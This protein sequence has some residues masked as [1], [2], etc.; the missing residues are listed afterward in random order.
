MAEEPSSPLSEGHRF[1]I[2]KSRVCDR[3]L[4]QAGYTIRNGVAEGSRNCIQQDDGQNGI[5]SAARSGEGILSRTG[6][7]GAL[8]S[9]RRPKWTVDCFFSHQNLFHRRGQETYFGKSSPP[10]TEWVFEPE[11][12]LSIHAYT[13]TGEVLVPRTEIDLDYK[14]DY[15][16][17]RSE[18][19][20]TD[21]KL[22]PYLDKKFLVGLY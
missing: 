6:L 11:K 5:L 8:I 17:I 9:F 19:G 16:T 22:E 15:L 21:S 1:Q 12:I 2:S 18:K 4:K 10:M 20:R 14:L 13:S 3:E 7:L